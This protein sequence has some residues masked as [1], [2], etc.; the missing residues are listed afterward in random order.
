[1][2]VQSQTNGHFLYCPLPRNCISCSQFARTSIPA[3]DEDQGQE[4]VL[5]SFASRD[6]YG[7]TRYMAFGFP[8]HWLVLYL[9][10]SKQIS[11][12]PLKFRAFQAPGPRVMLEGKQP[13]IRV[14]RGL[15]RPES[16]VS[17]HRRGFDYIQILFKTPLNRL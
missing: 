3:N 5:L 1:M 11:C 12:P 15:C 16:S 2:A 9:Q 4:G 14:P 13:A 17:M 10:Q 6:Q 7:S 8:C